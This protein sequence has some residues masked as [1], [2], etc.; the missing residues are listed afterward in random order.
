[1]KRLRNNIGND[2]IIVISFVIPYSNKKKS[3]STQSTVISCTVLGLGFGFGLKSL[4]QATVSL[5]MCVY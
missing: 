2:E 4:T 5:R 3:A 1:M